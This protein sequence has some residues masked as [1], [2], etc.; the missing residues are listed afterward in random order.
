MD[1]GE[2]VIR[3]Y[4][5]NNDNL[6]VL[7]VGSQDFNGSLRQYFS[8]VEEYIGTD[9]LDGPGVDIVVSAHDLVK[10]FGR[11]R[12]DVIVCVEMGEHDSAPWI[13]LDQIK[14]LLIDGGYLIYS[15]RGCTIGSNGKNG[16]SMWEHAYPNDYWRVLPQAWPLL[17]ELAGCDI[18]EYQ[19]DNQHPGG[20]MI[21]KRI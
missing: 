2:R 17:A 3:E 21:A 1:F 10:H 15:M 9:M 20:M 13:T 8:N 19:E 11:I 5:L 7:E 12:F 16:E 18:L 14:T 6:S 4:G